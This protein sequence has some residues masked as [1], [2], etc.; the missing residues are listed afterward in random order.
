MWLPF[1][2]A[3]RMTS[4]CP[5]CESHYLSA[6]P[7]NGSSRNIDIYHFSWTRAIY[8]CS[9]ALYYGSPNF[10]AYYRR[11]YALAHLEMW[12][13]AILGEF[14]VSILLFA[15]L[16]SISRLQRS[17]QDRTEECASRAVFGGGEEAGGCE[18]V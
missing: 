17:A 4:Q 3:L 7:R 5:P 6:L 12:D 13:K 11:G 10:K 9:A 14:K 18:G 15:S 2:S 1:G 8:D 16:I